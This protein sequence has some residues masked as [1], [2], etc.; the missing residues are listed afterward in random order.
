MTY[1]FRTYD[2][3][4]HEQLTKD[5][6]ECIVMLEEIFKNIANNSTELDTEISQII[7]DNLLELM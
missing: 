6:K 4:L 7:S 2:P 1:N 5:G 3:E